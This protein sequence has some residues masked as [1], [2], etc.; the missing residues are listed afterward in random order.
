LNT[1]ILVLFILNAG[2]FDEP[3]ESFHSSREKGCNVLYYKS[4]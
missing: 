3:S 2:F 1:V 4:F